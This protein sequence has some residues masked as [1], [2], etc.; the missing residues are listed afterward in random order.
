ME[1]IPVKSSSI[2]S[3]AHDP[4]TNTLEVRFASGDTYAYAGVDV[5]TFEQLRDAE[6][7]GKHFQR[8]IRGGGFTHTKLAT[9][10]QEQ[11][12]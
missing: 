10:A 5:A 2:Q 9:P 6:S 3:I 8:H 4:A 1:H 11:T 7:V 12:S